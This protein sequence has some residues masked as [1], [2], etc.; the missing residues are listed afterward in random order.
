MNFVSTDGLIIRT[1]MNFFELDGCVRS[2]KPLVLE[3]S[4]GLVI[5]VAIQLTRFHRKTV[6]ILELLPE[7][8]ELRSIYPHSG[9]LYLESNEESARA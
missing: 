2:G 6:L 3:V 1:S 5:G 4:Q 8:E 7:F 9:I